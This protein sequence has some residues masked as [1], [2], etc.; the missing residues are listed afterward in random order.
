MTKTQRNIGIETYKNMQKMSKESWTA[1]ESECH[2]VSRVSTL[3]PT[4]KVYVCIAFG[5]DYPS[6]IPLR[7]L[8]MKSDCVVFNSTFKIV[9]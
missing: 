8:V 3:V 2:L 1:P 6:Y 4:F 9:L 5:F 7:L